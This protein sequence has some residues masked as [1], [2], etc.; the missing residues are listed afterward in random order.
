MTKDKEVLASVGDVEVLAS[1]FGIDWL[2]PVLT[3]R[4]NEKELQLTTDAGEFDNDFG[5]FVIDTDSFTDTELAMVKD[6][7]DE[8]AD[9]ASV[10]EFKDVGFTKFALNKEYLEELNI[11]EI[12]QH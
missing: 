8:I 12:K 5:E 11:I 4:I 6:V 10:I 9:E 3:M 2:S 7:L 1:R